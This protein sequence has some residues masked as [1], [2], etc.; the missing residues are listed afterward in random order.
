MPVRKTE[1]RLPD[2]MIAEDLGQAV[3]VGN[4]VLISYLESPLKYH[5]ERK[6]IKNRYVLFDLDEASEP[7]N[8]SWRIRF[9]FS[10]G[11][12]AA[13]L[14]NLP[15]IDG[16]AVFHLD[17]EESEFGDLVEGR[18]PARLIVSVD[19][20]TGQQLELSQ[21]I[22]ALDSDIEDII[23]NSDND[24]GAIAGDPTTT[25]ILAN[26]Y[27]SHF[28][29]LKD[30]P[31]IDLQEISL[32]L[33]AALVYQATESDASVVS[34]DEK[35]WLD[36]INGDD[37][38]EPNDL[39]GTKISLM[40][41]RPHVFHFMREDPN[42][43]F[44]ILEDHNAEKDVDRY[45]S[46]LLSAFDQ[47]T[48]V[49]K[50]DVINT[51]RFP[52][53]C[54]FSVW[55]FLKL[56]KDHHA[57]FLANILDKD[58]HSTNRECVSTIVTEFETVPQDQLDDVSST[59]VQAYDIM[60]SRWMK[61]ILQTTAVQSER[62]KI[63]VLDVRSGRPVANT[64]VR[65]LTVYGKKGA[66]V[67]KFGTKWQL[68]LQQL[69]LLYDR[70]Q[71][72]E[73]PPGAS[74]DDVLRAAKVA[75]LRLGYAPPPTQR[76]LA[77]ELPGGW[78]NG[79]WD[80]PSS[81]AYNE[82]WQDRLLN[83]SMDSSAADRPSEEILREITKDYN[84]YSYTD[85]NGVIELRIPNTFLDERS[86]FVDIQFW[87]IPAF[88]EET[89][90]TGSLSRDSDSESTATGFKVVWTGGTGANQKTHWDDYVEV[91]LQF[92]DTALFG[93][94]I[95]H[96]G[97][98]DE[99]R[100]V[101]RIIIKENEDM[102]DSLDNALLSKFYDPINYPI[103]FVLFGLVWCQPA[104]D[105]FQDPV[106]P[107]GTSHHS[108]VYISENIYCNDDAYNLLT[109]DGYTD[110]AIHTTINKNFHIVS[111]VNMNTREPLRQKGYGVVDI[112]PFPDNARSNVDGHLGYDIYN[113]DNA[114]VFAPHGGKAESRIELDA[115]G[116]PDGFGHYT[117]VLWGNNMIDLAHL[118]AANPRPAKF[119]AGNTGD[120]T[121]IIAG[122]VIGFAGWSGN[123]GDNQPQHT[124]VRYRAGP[125]WAGTVLNDPP[126][127]DDPNR[128]SIPHNE[129]ALV[130]PCK[131]NYAAAAGVP[132][133]CEF[134]NTVRV[135]NGRRSISRCFA[136]IELCCPFMNV[137]FTSAK[138]PQKIQSQLKHMFVRNL[139]PLYMDPGPID[140]II[141]PANVNNVPTADLN[142]GTVVAL[143]GGSEH[144]GRLIEIRHTQDD[145]QTR[146]GW[147][148]NSLLDAANRL[149]IPSFLGVNSL[150]NIIGDSVGTSRMAIYLF[151]RANG[152]LDFVDYASNFSIDNQAW[153][154]LDA[155]V[156][157]R[158]P[159]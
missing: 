51:L 130:I 33:I 146:D 27:K 100:A 129:L 136:P 139:D 36:Y 67:R 128:F 37:R 15:G 1:S 111:N 119:P 102:F 29:T 28:L 106:I 96:E 89:G 57:E 73:P 56:L 18:S 155:I 86:V 117:R 75:L 38:V 13:E 154:T 76:T 19:T 55:R 141:I 94:R 85:D 88:I 147:I 104:W 112:R 84:V 14:P 118:R 62:V 44:I 39:V 54:I 59:A 7:A 45:E 9:E 126:A 116:L 61:A 50:I 69:D 82:Y 80:G 78:C 90:G 109:I 81:Q 25:R 40:N 135:L 3:P 30:N 49:G 65:R 103:H 120:P 115:A 105:D 134:R 124:H 2:G 60:Y 92:D 137:D 26:D 143:R 153:L 140:G 98:G 70:D 149:S 91:D 35:D 108:H 133:D 41:I 74:E 66:D 5:A 68:I 159:A 22:S 12:A 48:E 43:D 21:E 144:G 123:L 63:K 125:G 113:I 16:G 150:S 156:P 151:R 148:E 93:W 4:F 79:N 107:T 157:I 121:E 127:A 97:Q 83:N 142:N 71:I 34:P 77:E 145:G 10:D 24:K 101:N 64:K 32:N 6:L 31:A 132:R 138:A 42:A 47:W 72:P 131:C 23:A 11:S 99:L 95:S 53:S 87:E 8:Y 17:L 46:D 20:M 152:L 110:N 158:T 122:E 114:P 52:K 58:N